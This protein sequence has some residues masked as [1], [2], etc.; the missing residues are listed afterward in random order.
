MWL[1]RAGG[2]A[3]RRRLTISDARLATA[4]PVFVRGCP[5]SYIGQRLMAGL[6]ASAG[7]SPPWPRLQPYTTWRMTRLLLFLRLMSLPG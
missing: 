1:C 2:E 6:Q 7:S 5:L 4:C 3:V